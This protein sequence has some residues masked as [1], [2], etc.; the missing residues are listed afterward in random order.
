[1]NEDLY[2]PLL[3][4]LLAAAKKIGSLEEN[5]VTIERF[6]LALMELLPSAVPEEDSELS[7][8]AAFFNQ[9]FCKHTEMKEA[10]LAHVNRV[11]PLAILDDLE[12]EKLL[13]KAEHEARE[14]EE[15]NVDTLE[16]L[17]C[18]C[19]EPSALLLSFLS[20]V[21]D[22]VLEEPLDWLV[23][24]NDLLSTEE[25]PEQAPK[26]SPKD[27]EGIDKACRDFSE[28][29][30]ELLQEMG[31]ESDPQPWGRN[32]TAKTEIAELVEE[33]TKIRTALRSSIF[34]QEKAI[35]VFCAGY[36][37][38]GMLARLDKERRKPRATFLFAGPPGVGK[39]FLAEEVAEALGLPFR[40]FDMTEY[41]DKE[42]T[43]QFSGSDSVYKNG[44]PGNVTS[45]VKEH[46]KC[47]LLFDEVE[48]CHLNVVHLFL[49]ILDAGRLRDTCFEE[50]ISFR[51]AIII[52]TTNAGKQLYE[53]EKNL[54]TVSRKVVIRALETDMRPGTDVPMFPQA[55]C[56]RFAS[57][58]V[59]MFNHIGAH[60]LQAIA[61]RGIERLARDLEKDSG[62]EIKMDDAVYT[63]LLLSE[64]ANADARTIRA[65]AE[66]FFNDELYELLRLMIDEKGKDIVQKL[67]TV[68]VR[69][70]LDPAKKDIV[71]LF[72][73]D[74]LLSVLVLAEDE[75]VQRLQKK[76]KRC[77]L[78][79]VKSTEEAIDAVKSRH[80]D[81]ALLDI[82]YQLDWAEAGLNI[83]D[84]ESPAID[85]YRFMRK[86]GSSLPVY[87]LSDK[88]HPISDE[89][90]I[91]F[92]RAGIRGTLQIGGKG[93]QEGMLDEIAVQLY[94]QASLSRLAR[95]NK[96]VRFETA[97]HLSKN[98]K[99]ADIRLYD[100]TTVMA[101]DSEDRKKI[102]SAVSMPDVHFDD[103]IGARDAKKELTYFVEYLKNPRK[104]IGTG[105]KAPKG[106]LFYGP[107][108]TGKTMLAKAMASEAGVAFIAAEGNQFL[109]QHL[110]EGAEHV[111]EL[112]RTARKYAPAIL[113]ID[114]IDAIGKERSGA[115]GTGEDVLTAFL[116]EMDGFASDPNKP[117]FVLAATNFEVEAGSAKSLD[118]ALMRR[119]D[120]RIYI[121]LPRKAD[122]I[123]FLQLKREKNA[124]LDISDAQIENIALRA[125]GM[126]LADLDSVVELALRSAIREGST[127]VTDSILEEAFETF[128]GGEVKKWD[129]SLLERVACHE[130]GHALL[131][132]LA[133]QT[134][135]YLT[136][137]ARGNHGG[138]MQHDDQE[139]KKIYTKE[140]LLALIRTSMGGR[141]AEI[142]CYGKQDGIST[143]ASS[144]L[145]KATRRAKH[146]VCYYGMDEDFGLAVVDPGDN[147]MTREL[148]DAVNRILQAQM[149]E[150][151]RL[152]QENKDKLD[153]LVSV[154][155]AKNSLNRREI[156][157]TLSLAGQSTPVLL[158]E[159]DED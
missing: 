61:K 9:Q 13:R 115:A 120:R 41:A 94:Q 153:A 45:F 3:Q 2:S 148:R 139:E 12:M 38:A 98:G 54:A 103:V 18:I 42:A 159:V 119:F 60:H 92:L 43:L 136:I 152:L 121:D 122:R 101:V 117:V 72:E 155:L 74:E 138:Y 47:V 52:L 10:L 71:S 19:N 14:T 67:E 30:A 108:G 7:H 150:A 105:V 36:F 6:L 106:L 123:Q 62:L 20:S 114:E 111:H 70:E 75:L 66:S 57:G 126:S 129:A 8:T 77:R 69:V 135:A 102:L 25:T 50:P 1:M 143:G 44:H 29:A 137:V 90:K 146:L 56:S 34:G 82:G 118:P 21:E 46:P 88:K 83:E 11:D 55:I 151:I 97:Q 24:D 63:A 65:R 22:V 17:L 35:D 80:I 125:T 15:E 26:L 28:M 149:D 73:S 112:F 32:E 79:G 144:D 127:K 86:Q 124:A 100:L 158:A 37:Q 133:G 85:F 40:R 130:A 31:G 51:D 48:K 147:T 53:E 128:N 27:K 131:Y 33:T 39:T 5:P 4:Q 134:P 23:D 76:V 141:A 49:Q 95:E 78:F 84:A 58:N 132:W 113:F 81:F 91:S 156:E 109:K 145:A 87:L 140:E 116:A 96:I 99:I 89:E 107:P 110:G 16:L 157:K 104:Y 64:G 68:Q 154:L 59:V 93:S 142:V